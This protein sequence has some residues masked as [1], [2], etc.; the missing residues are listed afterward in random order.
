MALNN[1][2]VGV[3][4]KAEDGSYLYASGL[5]EYFPS[6]DLSEASDESLF[7]DDW[8]KLM[9]EGQR[10]VLATGKRSVVEL[11]R[12]TNSQYCA[13][14]CTIERYEAD[15]LAPA[16]LITFVDLT[17]ERKREDA[18][19]A[20]L[21]EVSHRS[22][23]LLAIVQSIAAQTARTSEGLDFFLTKFRGR[24]AALSSAQDLV[25]ESNWRGAQFKSLA[26]H[27]FMRYIEKGDRRV[28]ITGEDVLLS[29]NGA[30]HV[31]L[32][33]HELITNS[34]AFGA[35]SNKA[36]TLALDCKRLED[37]RYV[38]SWEER[39]GLAKTPLAKEETDVASRKQF[40]STVLE[41]VVPSAL[42]GD[43]D[44]DIEPHFVSYQLEFRV[45]DY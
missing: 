36:G 4:V 35:L 24:L 14:E 22:K 13:C 11:V 7:A 33:L 21:R 19:K 26:Q 2:Q 34:V 12:T 10:Q 38:I 25:T 9:Q 20:L 42:E 1:A 32:A 6:I 31:G 16:I 39:T 44:Y 17:P 3:V 23:N 30:T 8:L 29:P 15:G 45:A 5:P 18:L 28:S 41:R 37:G 40:G 43:A 27:Q